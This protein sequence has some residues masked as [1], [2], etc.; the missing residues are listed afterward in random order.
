MDFSE[1]R[2][3]L[4]ERKGVLTEALREVEQEM[5]WIDTMGGMLSKYNLTAA[6]LADKAPE[7]VTIKESVAVGILNPPIGSENT[8]TNPAPEDEAE[9]LSVADKVL[10]IS[11][12]WHKDLWDALSTRYHRTSAD[13]GARVGRSN[14]GTSYKILKRWY[15]AGLLERQVSRDGSHE[16]RRIA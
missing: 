15:D 7:P 6:D 11:R 12:A 1:L 8:H 4:N 2:H 16:Y 9:T 14:K 13:L 3:A 10:T 5:G